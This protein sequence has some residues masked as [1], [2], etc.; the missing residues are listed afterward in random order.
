MMK[1]YSRDVSFQYKSI[2]FPLNPLNDSKNWMGDANEPLKGFSWR[3]G[4]KRETIGVSMWSDVFLHTDE[5]T[6]EKLA[7]I[8]MDTKSY[9][10]QYFDFVDSSNE[11]SQENSGK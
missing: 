8:V 6:G 7:I 10:T 5:T 11:S 1:S 3:S 4:T 2:N 9:C